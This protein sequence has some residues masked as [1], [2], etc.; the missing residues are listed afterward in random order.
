[1]KMWKKFNNVSNIIS[2][3]TETQIRALFHKKNFYEDKIFKVSSDCKEIFNKKILDWLN[4]FKLK[5]FKNP[6]V[7]IGTLST[8][9]VFEDQDKFLSNVY[10]F[11]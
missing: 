6:S 7:E 3:S 9:P 5:K 10:N 2:T 11:N 1:M 4:R 8:V